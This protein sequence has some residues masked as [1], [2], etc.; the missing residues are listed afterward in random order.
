M[1]ELVPLLPQE[2]PS[3]LGKAAGDSTGAGP[4]LPYPTHVPLQCTRV[5][6]QEHAQRHIAVAQICAHQICATVAFPIG[7]ACHWMCALMGTH[8]LGVYS[9][10]NLQKR[11]CS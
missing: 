3:T 2:A 7:N 9:K 4:S 8:A 5:H 10:L 11:V 6:V 1:A